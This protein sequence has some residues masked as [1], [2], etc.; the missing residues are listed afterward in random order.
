MGLQAGKR[1]CPQHPGEGTAGPGHTSECSLNRGHSALINASGYPA[2]ERRRFPSPSVR[3]SLSQH[4]NSP[5]D[6]AESS[7]YS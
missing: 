4:I 2:P 7:L 3:I 6:L 1:F 5:G